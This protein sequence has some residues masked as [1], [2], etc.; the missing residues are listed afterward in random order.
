VS[1]ANTFERFWGRSTSFGEFV[2]RPS[3]RDLNGLIS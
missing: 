2:L 3:E 1:Y